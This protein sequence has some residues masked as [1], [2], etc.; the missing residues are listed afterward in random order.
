MKHKAL[1]YLFSLASHCSAVFCAIS[2]ILFLVSFICT[3][4]Y[5]GLFYIIA[6]SAIGLVGFGFMAEWFNVRKNRYND[7]ISKSMSINRISRSYTFSKHIKINEFKGDEIFINFENDEL[8]TGWKK[9]NFN[10]QM[11]G[12]AIVKDCPLDFKSS[13]V[14]ISVPGQHYSVLING[15]WRDG[16]KNHIWFSNKS[17]RSFEL[18]YQKTSLPKFIEKFLKNVS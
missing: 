13:I 4:F 18:P 15:V 10:F 12:R 2:F 5:E 3:I 11:L 9:Q 6:S 17:S 1:W 7:K 14:Y 8:V 16:D